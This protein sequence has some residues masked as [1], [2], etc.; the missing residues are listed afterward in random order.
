MSMG[1]MQ[2]P[3]HQISQRRIAIKRLGD[4]F[5]IDLELVVNLVD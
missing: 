1:D 5:K 4:S 2:T 3:S